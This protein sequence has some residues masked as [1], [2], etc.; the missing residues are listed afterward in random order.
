VT[1]GIASLAEASPILFALRVEVEG[2]FWWI[3]ASDVGG[4]MVGEVLFFKGT[5]GAANF[6]L[7]Y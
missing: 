1:L 4:I 6:F 5:L 3:G 2:A 7:L